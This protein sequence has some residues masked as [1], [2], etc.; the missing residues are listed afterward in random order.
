[1]GNHSGLN[2]RSDDLLEIDHPPFQSRV[3]SKSG[4]GIGGKDMYNILHRYC[5]DDKTTN[6]GSLNRTHTH[7]LGVYL[8][9]QRR[10]RLTLFRFVICRVTIGNDKQDRSASGDE[11]VP[12]NKL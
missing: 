7:E 1:M 2:F 5:H 4:K 3:F 11:F 9:V 6:D 12:I 8:N 10:R